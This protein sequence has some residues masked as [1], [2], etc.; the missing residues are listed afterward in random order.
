MAIIACGGYAAAPASVPPSQPIVRIGEPPSASPRVAD[1]FGVG[2]LRGNLTLL[3]PD[4]TTVADLGIMG[5]GIFSPDSCVSRV[6]TKANGITA[7]GAVPWSDA[8]QAA[9]L[10]NPAGRVIVRL[11]DC[12]CRPK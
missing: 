11:E 9:F 6:S 12:G 8:T 7:V 3:A 10:A 2:E 5:S 4:G 1:L